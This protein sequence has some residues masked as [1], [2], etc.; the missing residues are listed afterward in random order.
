MQKNTSKLSNPKGAAVLRI[1]NRETKQ[2]YKGVV[3]KPLS[4]KRFNVK[5]TPY[6]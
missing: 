3:S 5:R 4:P 6:K 2:A 1:W